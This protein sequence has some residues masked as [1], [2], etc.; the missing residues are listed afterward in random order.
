MTRKRKPSRSSF[1]SSRH[2]RDCALSRWLIATTTLCTWFTR[3]VQSGNQLRAIG[4]RRQTNSDRKSSTS[5]P[6]V[7]QTL[8]VSNKISARVISAIRHTRAKTLVSRHVLRTS[9]SVARN[10]RST[11]SATPRLKAR[12]RRSRRQLTVR[13]QAS[14]NSTTTIKKSARLRA[15]TGRF[16]RCNSNKPTFPRTLLTLLNRQVRIIITATT[17][18]RSRSIISHWKPLRHTTRRRRHTASQFDHLIMP[19]STSVRTISEIQILNSTRAQI[20]IQISQSFRVATSQKTFQR[21]TDLTLWPAMVTSSWMTT[22]ATMTHPSRNSRIFKLMHT[23]D[24][25]RTASTSLIISI[26]T[27]RA[28][29]VLRHQTMTTTMTIPA[30]T[31]AWTPA[32]C[33]QRDDLFQQQQQLQ[34]RPPLPHWRR[35]GPRR[36]SSE[37]GSGRRKSHKLTILT[38]TTSAMPSPCRQIFK[39]PPDP[40][41]SPT[42]THNETTS[43][44]KVHFYPTKFIQPWRQRGIKIKRFALLWAKISKLSRSRSR[45]RR[46][47]TRKIRLDFREKTTIM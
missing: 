7:P 35:R 21:Q 19:T 20:P 6:E 37:S 26:T 18:S 42:L 13:H 45:S 2:R 43:A 46:I 27:S 4:D 32:T 40:M 28:R 11:A 8:A 24:N 31:R 15:T 33:F 22:P 14:I 29:R 1:I 16:K 44:I 47:R 23:T 5:H 17:D 34:R 39:I 36:D 38:L 12:S 25:A 41:I 10:R 3:V 9:T 30:R